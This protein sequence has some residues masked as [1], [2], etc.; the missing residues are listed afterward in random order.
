MIGITRRDKIKMDDIRNKL[1]VGSLSYTVYNCRLKI[2]FPDKWWT[3]N[4]TEYEAVG[5]PGNYGTRSSNRPWARN[6]CCSRRRRNM[7]SSGR[8]I[9]HHYLR[10][11]RAHIRTP[12]PKLEFLQDVHYITQFYSQIPKI[13][14]HVGI[15]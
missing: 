11:K 8:P 14:Y 3:I 2:D 12:L 15:F 10:K 7:A 4:F 6:A 5:D 9:K 13:S 1:Q